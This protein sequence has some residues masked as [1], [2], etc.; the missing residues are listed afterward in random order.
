MV[1]I[2]PWFY[3]HSCKWQDFHRQQLGEVVNSAFFFFVAAVADRGDGDEK[4][5]WA[6][7]ED[8]CRGWKEEFCTGQE[9]GDKEK[10]YCAD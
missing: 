5:T 2:M 6:F 7:Q 3:G 4:H 1:I 8:S 9:A 10:Q